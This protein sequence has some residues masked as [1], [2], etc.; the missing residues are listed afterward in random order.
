MNPNQLYDDRHDW[1]HHENSCHRKVWRCP[2]HSGQAFTELEAYRGHLR[3]EHTD[4]GDDTSANRIIRASESIMAAIDRPCP[5]CSL[6]LDT[7]RALQSHIALHLERF[8]LF[9]LS[10]SIACGGDDD[11]DDNDVNNA[12]SKKAVGTLEDSRDENFEGDD[13]IKSEKPGDELED[14][15]EASEAPESKVQVEGG[16]IDASKRKVS[17]DLGRVSGNTIEL[18]EEAVQAIDNKVDGAGK[19]KSAE[20]EDTLLVIGTTIKVFED[21]TTAV[22]SVA[23]SPNDKRLASIDNRMVRLWNLESRTS[24]TTFE[25]HSSG[26]RSLAWSHDGRKLVS[27]SY[28]KTA[29]LWDVSTGTCLYTLSGHEGPVSGLSFSS[30]DRLLI[31]ASNDRTCKLWDV[32]TGTL[33]FT[34][35]GHMAGIWSVGISPNDQYIVSGSNDRTVKIWD[36]AT[37]ELVRTL[38]GHD[39]VIY[40][41]AFTPDSQILATGGND[42][43]IKLW[44]LASGRLLRST[45]SHDRGVT[46][47]AFSPDGSLMAS[48][49]YDHLIKIWE[50]ITWTNVGALEGHSADVYGVAF[51]RDGKCIASGSRDRTVRLW[52]LSFE[53]RALP[54]HWAAQQPSMV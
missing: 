47:L 21:H 29:K 3:N 38:K 7:P 40:A 39:R 22:Y 20:S 53:K 42:W 14:G 2:E 19:T 44:H 8:S 46:A 31:S 35:K 32:S 41:L 27:G 9:S 4:C 25:G 11:D 10:R 12:D 49:S 13:D 43:T 48:G 30:D 34:L 1:D 52:D 16:P 36:L 28:D 18:T 5:I 51:S 54:A 23:F 50:T 26:L 17:G 33:R 15:E 6:V 45:K 24:P 37:G